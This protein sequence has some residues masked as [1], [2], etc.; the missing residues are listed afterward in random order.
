MNL[1]VNFGSWK[2][3]WW[4]FGVVWNNVPRPQKGRL[5]QDDNLLSFP[6]KTTN[7]QREGGSFQT[8]INLYTTLHLIGWGP[9]LDVFFWDYITNM[10]YKYEGYIYQHLRKGCQG[11]PKGW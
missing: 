2:K 7:F 4:R 1:G 10:K 11:N 3:L 8:V 9:L 6:Y 5:F